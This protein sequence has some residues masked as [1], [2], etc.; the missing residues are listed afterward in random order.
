MK[1]HGLKDDFLE[2]HGSDAIMYSRIT[3]TSKTRIDYIFSNSSSCS[4]FQY[5]DMSLG[6]DHSAMIARY[7]VAIS[8]RKE[9]IP[10]DRFF[11]GWVISRSLEMDDLFLENSRLI[12]KL[13]KE[14]LL[15]NSDVT[16]D[17]SFYWLKAKTAII[18]LAKKREKDLFISENEKIEVLKGFYFSALNDMK[19]GIDC[20]K[21][22]DSI[23]IE[24]D[25]IY[26]ERS[27]RKVDKM[28]GIQINDHSFDIHKLQNQRKYENQRKINE[29]K[30]GG[31]LYSGTENVVTAIEEKMREELEPYSDTDFI[32]PPTKEE[33]IFLKTLSKIDLTEAERNELL[34]TIKEEE[35]S[36]I[37]THEV[38]KDSSP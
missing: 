26:Q 5:I 15:K 12:F 20:L 6:L 4:Y 18:S 2:V 13:V 31:K 32:S 25:K 30:I 14:E 7:D 29:I 9:C 8:I 27:K 24:L 1:I 16:L 36:Y 34:S 17:P 22:I 10:R 28:R 35:I 38:E 33:E 19:N 23:K 37:L 11:S 3:P 21:E